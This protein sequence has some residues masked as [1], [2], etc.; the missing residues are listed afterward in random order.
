MR[1]RQLLVVV[2]LTLLAVVGSASASGA[3]AAD[4][5]STELTATVTDVTDGD[6]IDVEYTNGTNDTVRMLGVD[7]PEVYG[8]NDP[9]E[10]EGVP[11]T[12][13]GKQ[14][15]ANAG[16]NASNYTKNELHQ[17]EQVTLE[18]DPASDGRGDYGRLLAYVL[19]DG[20]NHNYQLIQTGHARVYDSE[21]SQSERFY[22]AESDA[23]SD[24]KGLW[25]CR[26]GSGDGIAITQIHADAAGNDNHNLNDEYVVLENTGQESLDVSG[27]TVSDTDEETYTFPDGTGLGPG[28]SLTL[29]TG[30][31]SNT[32]SDHYWGKGRAIWSNDGET[33]T[34]KDDTGSLVTN[35]SY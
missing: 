25:H 34:V 31:G 12:T 24:R 21:F 27:W 33:A 4:I 22:A 20:E 9:A 19:D 29:H 11:N 32:E 23:Q 2:V 6:T 7:T 16:E 30:S 5:Q 14:C 28:E 26:D 3:M 1:T 17:G 10:F 15:L 8:E 35:R 13:E 18:L